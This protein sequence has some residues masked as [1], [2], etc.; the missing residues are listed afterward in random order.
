MSDNARRFARPLEALAAIERHPG[1]MITKAD[2]SA[3]MRSGDLQ[4]LA[5]EDVLV[6]Q[7]ASSISP[8]LTVDDVDEFRRVFYG[9]CLRE[10][11]QDAWTPSRDAAGWELA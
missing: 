1:L 11:P 3:W 4:T 7:A 5:V 6:N 2:M 8:L 10:N 9:R